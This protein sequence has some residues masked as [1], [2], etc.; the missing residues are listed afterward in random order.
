M[1]LGEIEIS[2]HDGGYF[3]LKCLK[4]LDVL[5]GLLCKQSDGLTLGEGLA[6]LDLVVH[7]QGLSTAMI[8]RALVLQEAGIKG[9]E[10]LYDDRKL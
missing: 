2:V 3:D 1:S 10:S 6:Q 5:L 7:G 8:N 4:C 9:L